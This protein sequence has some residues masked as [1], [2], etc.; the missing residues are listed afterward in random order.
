MWYNS[1]F[2]HVISSFVLFPL[3]KVLQEISPSL[4][5]PPICSQTR[6]SMMPC[7]RRWVVFLENP[8]VFKCML[9]AVYRDYL[10]LQLYSSLLAQMWQFLHSPTPTNKIHNKNRIQESN[11]VL[12]LRSSHR[13]R[14]LTPL[15][16]R[17]DQFIQNSGHSSHNISDCCKNPTCCLCRNH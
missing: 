14:Q 3:C 11:F 2:C 6:N 12:A 1:L 16:K 9:P 8:T 7:V 10:L 4:H 5:F 15:L 17:A 13:S